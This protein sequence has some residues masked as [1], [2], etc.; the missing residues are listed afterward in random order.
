MDCW[1]N[2]FVEEIDKI[3]LSLN[4]DIRMQSMDS[5]ETCTWKKQR[6]TKEKEQIKCKNIIKQYKND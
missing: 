6:F 3:A 4:D 1:R 2:V 5:I